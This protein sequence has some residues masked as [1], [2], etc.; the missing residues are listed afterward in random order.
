MTDRHPSL[1]FSPSLVTL[2]VHNREHL[3]RLLNQ[4]ITPSYPTL[5]YPNMSE[6]KH[7][8]IKNDHGMP[9]VDTE[10]LE[11]HRVGLIQSI[12]YDI[13]ILIIRST[14]PTSPSRLTSNRSATLLL[15]SEVKCKSRAGRVELG[16]MILASMSLCH[17]SSARGPLDTPLSDM[18]LPSPPRRLSTS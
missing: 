15:P 5:P 16:L 6:V 13:S 3:V 18:L 2:Y 4:H 9:V 14:S 1:P 12:D 8:E 7:A 10:V 17:S 11:G